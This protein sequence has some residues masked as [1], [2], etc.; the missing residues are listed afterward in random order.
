MNR[1]FTSSNISPL[2]WENDPGKHDLFY[3]NWE[4][5]D[6]V[7]STAIE[8]VLF[9]TLKIVADDILKG[10]E[11]SYLNAAKANDGM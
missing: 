2:I 1:L 11:F 4:P 3:H 8:D 10:S 9:P 6:T 7:F 5:V